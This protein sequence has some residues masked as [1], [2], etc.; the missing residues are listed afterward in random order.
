MKRIAVLTSGG[1]AQGMNAAVRAVV[2][3]A[4]DHGLDV[5][6]IYEGYQGMVDGGD[7][8]RPIRW[9]DVGGILHKGGTI[10]GSARSA[11][12]RERS[13]RLKAVRNLLLHKIEGIVVIGGDG[14][15]TGANILYEEWPELVAELVAD[16]RIGATTAAQFPSL[17]VAGIIGS[18]DNDMFGSDVTTGADTALH[19]IVE[20]TDA[21]TSTAASHQRS[22]VVEV[23]GRHCGYLALMGALAAGA[24]WVL[25]PESPPDV[26]DWAETMCR[27]LRKGRETGRRD[28]LVVIAEGAQD[29]HGNPI[30][31]EQ[32]KRILEERLGE[33]TRITVLGHVQRGGAPSAFDRNLSTLLGS[34]AVVELISA[35]TG[36]PP[37]V[38]GMRGNK[39]TRTPLAEALRVTNAVTTAIVAQNYDEALRLRGKSFQESFRTVRTLV[40]ALPHP[41]TPGQRRMRIA[42][43]NA[44][45]PAPGMNTAVRAA[46]R[47]AV[48]KGHIVLGIRNG[49]H[50]LI[51]DDI[52]EMDW[53]SVSGW[54][55]RGGSE[56]GTNRYLPHGSDYY[57]MA[58]NL[59]KYAIDG[60]LMIGGWT[61]Y[62][63]GLELHRQRHTFPAFDI[64]I[65]CLPVSINNNLPGAEL[66]VGADTA[67]NSIVS[68]VDKIKRSAVASRRAFVVEVMGNYCGYLA[69]MSALATGAERVYLHE[70][71]VT[72]ADLE[73]DVRQLVDGF[74]KGKRL[75]LMIRN[76]YANPVYTTGFMRA[77]FEEEGGDLFDVRESILGHLQQGGDPSPFDRI[78]ATRLASQCVDYLEKQIGQ[79]EPRSA[80]VG[81]VQGE[82]LFTEMEDIARLMDMDVHRPKRQWWL[83]IRPIARVLAKPAPQTQSTNNSE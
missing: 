20:A 75:G 16:G 11:E 72:L 83:D 8:I 82:L 9:N 22:F 81:Q 53:M 31:S 64:P 12:F 61:G 18:I 42:V 23:M 49:F 67:L 77:L 41:P 21:I 63:G 38:M 58:R 15:L 36:T 34:A 19:R 10:I 6:A 57:A 70:E 25:I 1:D 7:A 5:F 32:I 33:D 74:S 2:R 52:S 60:I 29:R 65:V 43:L 78:L 28:T 73:A 51:E 40:R 62:R 59:E 4:L 50:G 68:A 66:S 71:G 47:L 46:V 13:G 17:A 39:L 14:S 44:G 24:D 56:L 54:A 35:E 30:T 80:C 55:T 76:E 27:L 3:T 26:D 37:F 69:L 45:G 79:P 48:D